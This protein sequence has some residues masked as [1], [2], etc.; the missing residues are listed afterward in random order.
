MR[1]FLS[2]LSLTA[3]LAAIPV[4]AAVA[5]VAL[6]GMHQVFYARL[7][8]G[9][10]DVGLGRDALLSQALIGVVAS[11]IA[12][13]IL[14]SVY[15]FVIVYGISTL[16][17]YLARRS[18]RVLARVPLVNRGLPRRVRAFA[19]RKDSKAVAGAG[20]VTVVLAVTYFAMMPIG[21]GFL[22]NL[23]ADDVQAGYPTAALELPVIGIPFLDVEANHFRFTRQPTGSDSVTA[24]DA[25]CMLYLGRTERTLAF[26][27]THTKQPVRLPADAFAV[28][29]D[30]SD[31]RL[32]TRCRAGPQPRDED[33][34]V[35][36]G[37]R[38]G[39]ISAYG[40][41]VAWTQIDRSGRFTL[42][43]AESGKAH[44]ASIP[45]SD[46]TLTTDL[47]PGPSGE[48]VAAYRRC[49]HGR[50]ALFR[51]DVRKA[52]ETRLPVRQVRDCTTAWPAVWR[53][54][55]VFLRRGVHCPARERGVWMLRGRRLRRLVADVGS[56]SRQLDLR[57]TT[58]VWAD[59]D[60]VEMRIRTVDSRF[61]AIATLYRNQ[62]AMQGGHVVLASPMLTRD[63]VVWSAAIS[64]GSRRGEFQRRKRH[65]ARCEVLT[66]DLASN[67]VLLTRDSA[68]EY[69]IDAAVTG[70]SIVYG[71]D[72]ALYARQLDGSAERSGCEN[73]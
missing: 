47:G 49:D 41:W 11:G 58:A 54:V 46:E 23:Y 55:T 61:G 26:Y 37:P 51:Y 21:G 56:S 43:L 32:P 53:R 72:G 64:F 1:R 45:P 59:S 3:V 16:V 2:S 30:G 63:A 17:P 6:Y 66:D 67:E 35:A 42:V 12:I 25:E 48:P 69:G 8:F 60:G 29:L 38:L 52:I 19:R 40:L 13:T 33:A 39:D 24:R 36:R 44:A 70:D 27:D 65:S 14:A 31:W 9:V 7:G 71:T 57:G 10:D 68:A 34:F 62:L 73:R 5:Y 22:A 20:K 18:V 4:L 28:T 15:L 50:C